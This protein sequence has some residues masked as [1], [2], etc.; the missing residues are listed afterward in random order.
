MHK[1]SARRLGVLA[2]L[3]SAALAGCG[4]TV[5]AEEPATLEESEQ[6]LARC[7][8]IDGPRC[9]GNYTC[10]YRTCRPRC[11]TTNYVCSGG[12]QCCPGVFDETTGVG[13][14]PYCASVCLE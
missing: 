7:H 2:V 6:E 11:D 13:S 14:A 8:P 4:G 5:A 1:R 12:L 10:V 9:S 3:I